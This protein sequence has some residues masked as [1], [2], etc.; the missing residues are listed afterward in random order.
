MPWYFPWSESIKKRACR[1]L[2]QHYL[3]Q[4]LKEKLTLDQLSV[5]LYNGTGTIHD[6]LLDVA[7]LNEALSNSNVPIE[8]VDGFIGKITV[9]I[10]W[11]ALVSDNTCMQIHNLELTIQPKQRTDAPGQHS[12]MLDSMF[13][14]MTTSMQLAQE[15]LRQDP[16]EGEQ[17]AE[18]AQ[19]FEGLEVFAQTIEAVLSR[20]KVSFTDTILRLEH[21]PV[22]SPSGA[23][24]EVRIARYAPLDLPTSSAE[25]Q[26]VYEPAAVA[27]KNLHLMGVTLLC[28]EFPAC[29]RTFTREAS[30]DSAKVSYLLT[31]DTSFS[32]ASSPGLSPRMSPPE[33][34]SCV[35]G[36]KDNDPIKIAV[37]SGRQELKLKVKQ[38]EELSGPKLELSA[39]VGLIN[40]HLSPRQVHLLLEIA[41]GLTT[42][43]LCD[44]SNM[45]P[46]GSK[47]MAAEDYQRVEQELQNQLSFGRINY[48]SEYS[49]ISFA[50][51]SDNEDDE[52]YFDLRHG[53]PDSPSMQSSFASTDT[54]HSTTTN[55]SKSRE[56]RRDPATEV[57]LPLSFAPSLIIF[58]LTVDSFAKYLDD[59]MAEVTKYKLRASFI[60]MIVLHED[61]PPTPSDGIDSG[62]S[63]TQ[64]LREMSDKFFG[65]IQGILTPGMHSDLV[66]LR[67][68][69]SKACPCDHL[70]Y[71]QLLFL[72]SHRQSHS[73][74]LSVSINL[75]ISIEVKS[76]GFKTQMLSVVNS[77]ESRFNSSREFCRPKVP[78][79]VTSL[80][81]L[82]SN[83]KLANR[84]M[85]SPV[86]T[87]VN[88]ELAPCQTEVD[89]TI[90]DR[91]QSLLHPQPLSRGSAGSFSQSSASVYASA[92]QTFS[93][94]ASMAIDEE[95]SLSDRQIDLQAS[96][97]HL[98]VQLRFPIPDLRSGQSIDKPW[99]R[100]CL[101][102]ERL[103]LDLRDTR[104][105]TSFNDPRASSKFEV[106]CREGDAAFQMS[107]TQ[108]AVPFL[109]LATSLEDHLHE[110]EEGF[111]WPRVVVKSYPK[112]QSVLEENPL[113]DSDESAH[114][115]SLNGACQFARHS[116]SPFSTKRVMYDNEELVMPGDRKEM[117]DFQDK[118]L[119][120]TLMSFEMNFPNINVILPE[121][122]LFETLY[123]RLLDDLVLW[124]PLAPAP[125]EPAETFMLSQCASQE[126]RKV[127]IHNSQSAN[128]TLLPAESSSGEDESLSGHFYSI[129]DHKSKQRISPEKAGE[130]VVGKQGEILLCIEEGIL[131]V[132][133]HHAGDPDLQ[134][135][136]IQ[137]HNAALYHC[138]DMN[139]TP[140][141][142]K[143][144]RATMAPPTH[145]QPTIYLSEPGVATKL[146][147]QVGAGA[148][149]MDMLSVALKIKMD[150]FRNI[151]DYQIAVGVRGATL[152]H[153]VSLPGH[154]WLTNVMEV[155]DLKEHPVLGY[156]M[157][158]VV[159]EMHLHL[160]SCAVDYRPIHL[161][162][163]AMVT[164][165][166]FSISSN[167]IAESP[168]SLLRFLV[169]DAA[170]YLS[171][172]CHAHSVDL[173]KNYVCVLDVGLFELSL[174]SSDGKD[175]RY[176]KTDLRLSNNIVHLRTC[177]D[178]CHALAELINYIA[179][180]GDL[181]G[182]QDEEQLCLRKSKDGE[183]RVRLLTSKPIEIRDHHFAMPLGKADL[184][185]APD[186]FPNAVL[187]YTLKEMSV[188]WYMYGGRDFESSP[189][190]ENRS[191][192]RLSKVGWQARGGPGRDIEVLMELQLSKVRFQH[193]V[194][195]ENTQQASRQVMLVHEVEL[196]DRLASSNINKFLYQYSSDAVPR[197]T[198]AYMV[199]VKALHVR[200]DP[201][202]TTQECSLRV[203][204]QPLRLNI[205]QDALFFLRT[206]FSE[207][208]GED[209]QV[210]PATEAASAGTSP[211][212]R[213]PLADP[214]MGLAQQNAQP[215]LADEHLIVFDEIDRADED[216]CDD[217]QLRDAAAQPPVFFKSFVFT[218]DVPIRL[219]YH[220]KRVDME[221]G[222]LI[223]LLV[224]LA[225]L[226]CSELKLRSINH[227]HGL[228][229]V[230]RLM[231]HCLREW[232]QDITKN[233]LPSILG[234]V[235][236]LHSLVQ[237]AQGIR[238]L[239]WLPVEQYRK[240]G[241]IVRGIQRGANSFMT[242]TT[243]SMLELTNRVI[244]TVQVTAE[245]AYD[246][247]S[248]GPGVRHMKHRKRRHRRMIH[249]ADFRE[250]VSNAMTIV[251]EGFRGTVQ[252]IYNVACCEHEQ[253]GVT[254]AVGGVVRQIPPTILDPVIIA[255]AA[256]SNVLGGMR[257]QLL[258]DK[259]REDDEK[260]KAD[261]TS[262]SS[263]GAP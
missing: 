25:G 27:H 166:T 14:G 109:H 158:K 187:R 13:G 96:C 146:N 112:R 176:P 103:L 51:D 235:G 150:T 15:C 140:P 70:G 164:M 157:P 8:I 230:D 92:Y 155:F 84:H 248:P 64:K 106:T 36:S 232:L 67:G 239:F 113:E 263:G 148:E 75:N 56:L 88:I 30:F 19:P 194:Y 175:P 48:F 131:F 41:K 17:V 55:A 107:A 133:V 37:L 171:D 116:S 249:P 168:T 212:S 161:P 190:S 93:G 102:P 21:L 86:L 245:V 73:S 184:L 256:T 12:L 192:P 87:K 117:A 228:L 223:G 241:R 78:L 215:E 238:D 39:Q 255:T 127:S 169:D 253:K 210:S 101:R 247:V 220:G 196:R 202:L 59:P 167:I 189:P 246:M 42:P 145:L 121:K 1:Y 82:P 251:K 234:G 62:Q 225:H 7:S 80:N 222:T 85:T 208:A 174:R 98:H 191:T 177:A 136:C 110:R 111:D 128:Q 178:S 46:R 35:D 6:V 77:F 120:S 205:D 138:G 262:G 211:P 240:D 149:S 3:G 130:V 218:P 165:E 231:R 61:P 45:R 252:N 243:M 83:S 142:T 108:S 9:S 182:I 197:Q 60:S 99:W 81:W 257:N 38:S 23:A 216:D 79:C 214:V 209:L 72:I 237:L 156:T 181:E 135:M 104:F 95:S 226:N 65:R 123:N 137:A 154:S 172:R 34:S 53:P 71:V 199:L 105:E 188:V 54:A 219:D 203:S 33:L 2:L 162:Y 160:W 32:Q 152:H 151:K 261:D 229:G 204:L 260:W 233:Q 244:Q 198:H 143:I 185:K 94:P 129:Y 227:R 125:L 193:E 200:P 97:S 50:E 63:S 4:F 68:E 147:G 16:T 170:L 259:K 40:V 118:S 213:A 115:D 186:H 69:Y 52:L 76:C 159:T 141:P 163:R 57:P 207:L 134:Y 144:G 153:Q 114:G 11:S 66:A 179:A 258:P 44:T 29:H 122:D 10:P 224:G 89:V 254:G 124:E 236:P 183:P 250:G 132:Q 49:V 173:K 206:F 242:C 126:S 58:T 119:S 90:I 31:H 26:H 91:I 43:G 28:D 221:Q 20:V 5:D 22:D 201:Q 74:G 24:L 100:R 139:T 195:P 217:D 47:P 18:A 180:D